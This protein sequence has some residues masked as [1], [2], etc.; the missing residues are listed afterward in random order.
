M[1]IQTWITLILFGGLLGALGQ[2]L[3]SVVG[4]KKLRDS[5]GDDSA[6]YADA[7]SAS[8]LIV[9]VFVGFVTGALT[10][11]TFSDQLQAMSA[12]KEM[13]LSVIAAGYAGT[14]TIEGLA[15]K[16]PLK[17]NSAGTRPAS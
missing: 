13:V 4:L 15:S 5:V 17:K 11:L 10:V 2:G 8:R 1:N 16:I 9:T 12:S 14:D 3:R 6:A 7:F